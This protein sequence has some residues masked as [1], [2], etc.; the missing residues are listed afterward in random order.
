MLKNRF[1]V[2]YVVAMCTNFMRW[3]GHLGR[4]FKHIGESEV[5]PDLV[6]LVAFFL[7]RPCFKVSNRFFE[8]VYSLN[9]R[10]LLRL[11]NEQARLGVP[12]GVIDLKEFVADDG[13]IPRIYEQ[14]R[15]V[16]RDLDAARRSGN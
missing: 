11:Y 6:K 2:K 10:E 5:V 16:E 1:L 3:F 8:I 7:C 4:F 14:L 9:Q 12:Q 13:I 15:K